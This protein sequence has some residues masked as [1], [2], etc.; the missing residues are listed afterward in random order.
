MDNLL[1]AIESLNVVWVWIIVGVIAASLGIR[2][3]QMLRGLFYALG[4]LPRA[5][6]ELIRPSIRAY[7]RS[8]EDDHLAS[9]LRYELGAHAR[10][11]FWPNLLLNLFS[12]F[13]ANLVFFALGI[14]VTLWTTHPH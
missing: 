4:R 13:F 1:N 10:R 14:I 8:P 2:L 7:K 3:P 6:G 5:V 12:S 11:S 9:M